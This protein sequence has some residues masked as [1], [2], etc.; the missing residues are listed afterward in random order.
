MFYS[1]KLIEN[2]EV[3]E[4]KGF[5]KYQFIGVAVASVY[6]GLLLHLLVRNYIDYK[7]VK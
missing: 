3:I 1:K 2:G 5:I 4:M 6:F 7:K